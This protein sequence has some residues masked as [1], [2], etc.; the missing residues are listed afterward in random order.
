MK[1]NLDNL[2]QLF[3]NIIE[4]P[5]AWDGP[6][7]NSAI[8]FCHH[9]EQTKFLFLVELFSEIF[10]F[11]DVLFNIIQ[12]KSFDILY[13]KEQLDKARVVLKK[14]LDEF[15]ALRCLKKNMV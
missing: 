10:S 13:C 5:D 12:I 8:G 1:E 14:K 2:K 9:L 4:N 7:I 3:E 11:T 6:T 15:A